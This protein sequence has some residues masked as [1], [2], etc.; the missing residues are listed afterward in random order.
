MTNDDRCPHC[1]SEEEPYF[2]RVVPMGYFCPD[3]GRGDDEECK[4]NNYVIKFK[5]FYNQ[6][7]YYEKLK[8]ECKVSDVYSEDVTFGDWERDLRESVLSEGL[9]TSYP[10]KKVWEF[11]ENDGWEIV[12]KD[13]D[14]KSP[15]RALKY[16]P[17]NVKF[18]YIENFLDTLGYFISSKADREGYHRI[19]IEQKYP[20][21]I[22]DKMEHIP[23]YHV[24]P[25][26][27]VSK[28]LKIG[29]SPRDSKTTFNH[30]GNRIYLI[31][32]DDLTNVESLRDILMTNKNMRDPDN[33]IDGMSILKVD[34]RGINLYIDP[35][36]PSKHGT[37]RA[38][39]TTQNIHPKRIS[40]VD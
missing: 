40:V 14:M 35:M 9:I 34:V 6:F 38:C 37:F 10:K 30:P 20:E 25:T 18:E 29:L 15:I 17:K 33:Q 5:D 4:L 27:N 11:L 1:G 36:F 24:A 16:E 13:S 2:S 32:T 28:I 39:F 7:T 23:Y 8:N 19:T 12:D 31:Q 26:K 22:E 3:C 21:K